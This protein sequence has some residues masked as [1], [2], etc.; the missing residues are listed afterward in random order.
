MTWPIS[1]VDFQNHPR[2][3]LNALNLRVTAIPNGKPTPVYENPVQLYGLR[4]NE[5]E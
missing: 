1:I 2:P 5:M 4:E 3:R